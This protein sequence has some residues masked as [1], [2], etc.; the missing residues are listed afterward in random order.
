MIKVKKVE[1]DFD[2][3]LEKGVIEATFEVTELTKIEKEV[4]KWQLKEF[5]VRFEEQNRLEIECTKFIK[6]E[7]I[8]ELIDEIKEYIR[9]KKEKI[10]KTLTDAFVL[11][12]FLNNISEEAD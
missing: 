2:E 8:L 9:E 4:L 6:T 7:T 1:F 5:T 3:E 11:K 10:E 12:K